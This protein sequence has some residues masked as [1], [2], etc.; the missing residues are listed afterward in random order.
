MILELVSERVSRRFGLNSVDDIQV[1]TPTH[2]G[3]VGVK[4]LNK[5]LQTILNP[6]S[7]E[8]QRGNRSFRAGDKVMQIR[9][10]YEKDVFNCD[11]GRS[12]AGTGIL[13][14]LLELLFFF[15][16]CCPIRS[17]SP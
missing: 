17:L 5:L 10:N 1:I 7:K 4:N 11:I 14:G 6:G 16:Y 2:C 8:L 12:L 15:P 13:P 3:A 9:N